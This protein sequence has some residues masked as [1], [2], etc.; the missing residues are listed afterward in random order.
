[1]LE[2]LNTGGSGAND[3]SLP[4]ERRPRWR[5][6]QHPMAGR[7]GCSRSRPAARSCRRRTGASTGSLVD[8]IYRLSVDPSK[9]TA[10]GVAMA[11]APRR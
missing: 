5:R 3:G 10:N 4:T 1:M 8:G 6:R 11:A 7:R 9:V 2:L